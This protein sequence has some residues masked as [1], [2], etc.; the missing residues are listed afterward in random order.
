MEKK[1]NQW[2]RILAVLLFF[3]ALGFNSHHN[4]LAAN[5]SWTGG[6]WTVTG[7]TS[8]ATT[9]LATG[10]TAGPGD[11]F[12]IGDAIT[13]AAWVGADASAGSI[14]VTT[15]LIVVVG[16]ITS[17]STLGLPAS[18]YDVTLA[19]VTSVGGATL[20][21]PPSGSLTVSANATQLPTTITVNGTLALTLATA[22]GSSFTVNG[23]M[24]APALD[25]VGEMTV[26]DGGSLTSVLTQIAR[27]FRVQS[28]AVSCATGSL[29]SVGSITMGAA[30]RTITLG[31]AT[32]G[33][34]TITD[35][36]VVATGLPTLASLAITRPGV[37]NG[38]DAGTMVT[39]SISLLND[40]VWG[41]N[42]IGQDDTVDNETDFLAFT[43]IDKVT[44]IDSVLIATT[45][46]GTCYWLNVALGAT[47]DFVTTPA[48]Y[49]IMGTVTGYGTYL[50]SAP[51]SGGMSWKVG[52]GTPNLQWYDGASP[53]GLPFGESGLTADSNYIFLSAENPNFSAGSNSN[54]NFLPNLVFTASLTASTPS[55]IATIGNIIAPAG[56]NTYNLVVGRNQVCT[57]GVIRAYAGTL[58]LAHAIGTTEGSSFFV[59]AGSPSAIVSGNGTRVNIYSPFTMQDSVLVQNTG[60][61]H[62]QFD[63]PTY[64][65]RFMGDVTV[66]TSGTLEIFGAGYSSLDGLAAPNILFDSTVFVGDT[67][68]A[69]LGNINGRLTINNT[70]VRFGM[71]TLA[72]TTVPLTSTEGGSTFDFTAATVTYS[73][74][75]GAANGAFFARDLTV[76][77]DNNTSF[78]FR[79]LQTSFPIPQAGERNLYNLEFD[80]TMTDTVA[81]SGTILNIWGNYILSDATSM[82][83][84]DR[85]TVSVYGTFDAASSWT[86]NEFPLGT[87]LTL[88]GPIASIGSATAIL[89]ELALTITGAGRIDTGSTYSYTMPEAIETLFSFTMS[90]AGSTLVLQSPLAISGGNFNLDNGILVLAD[91]NDALVVDPGE[92]T[93]GGGGILNMVGGGDVTVTFANTLRNDGDILLRE[94]YSVNTGTTS[95]LTIAATYAG[96]GNIYTDSSS[97][98]QYGQTGTMNSATQTFELPASVKEV[99]TLLFNINAGSMLN[100]NGDL[101]VITSLDNTA[102][103]GPLNVGTNKLTLLAPPVAVIGTGAGSIDISNS[104][105]LEMTGDAAWADSVLITSSSSNVIIKGGAWTPANGQI[106]ALNNLIVG[107]EAAAG[108]YLIP[109]GQASFEIMGNL[110]I[111]ADANIATFTAT[112]INNFIVNGDVILSGNAFR[113]E[114]NITAANVTLNGMLS[115]NDSVTITKT[116]TTQLTIGGTAKRFQLHP[117]LDTLG[118]LTLNR[119]AGLRLNADSVSNLLDT[120]KVFVFGAPTPLGPGLAL[121]IQ[122][123]QFDLNGCNITFAAPED[124]LSETS[125][126]VVINTGTS[127]L[128]DTLTETRGCI[129]SAGASSQ[130]QLESIGF[131]GGCVTELNALTGSARR[132]PKT[133]NVPEVG[134]ATARYYFLVAA[135]EPAAGITDLRLAYDETELISPAPALKIYVDATSGGNATDA[136]SNAE[137][138]KG[139]IQSIPSATPPYVR[140]NQIEGGESYGS[141]GPGLA[142]ALAGPWLFALASPPGDFGVIKRFVNTNNNNLWFDANNWDPIGVPTILDQVQIYAIPGVCQVRITGD[143]TIAEAG[144]LVL[145]GACITLLPAS[146]SQGQTSNLMVKGNIRVEGEAAIQGIDGRN[147][148]NLMIGDGETSNGQA[149]SSR[150]SGTQYTSGTDLTSG[151][152][153]NDLIINTASFTPNDGMRV[154]G[155]VR[156]VNNGVL[157]QQAGEFIFWGGITPYIDQRLEVPASA[158]AIFSNILVANGARVNTEANLTLLGAFI[159]DGSSSWDANGG[160]V[161]ATQTIGQQVW[162]VTAP[163]QLNLF[164]LEVGASE[165]DH[166]PQGIVTIKANFNKVGRS[167]LYADVVRFNSTSQTQLNK[168]GGNLIFNRLQ[169]Y[170]RTSCNT[171]ASFNIFRELNVGDYATLYCQSGTIT[172]GGIVPPVTNG[173]VKTY[174]CQATTGDPILM[175]N[176]SATTLRHF[177]VEVLHPTVTPSNWQLEGDL[178]VGDRA[179]TYT[180]AS[181]TQTNGTTTTSNQQRRRIINYGANPD[182]ITFNKLFVP[183]GANLTTGPE[184][185]ADMI[186]TWVSFVIKNYGANAS[187]EVPSGI[188]IGS[189]GRFQQH[190]FGVVYFATDGNVPTT[191]PAKTIINPGRS[192]NLQFGNI[193]IRTGAN[194]A[195]TTTSEFEIIGDSASFPTTLGGPAKPTAEFLLAGAG[196]SFTA[197]SGTVHFTNPYSGSTVR[198]S[199]LA[200]ATA[201]FAHFR[202]ANELTLKLKAGDEI[203]ISGDVIA[204]GLSV[205]DA[206]G[207]NAK[208]Q[209]NGLTAPQYFR[210]TSTNADPFNFAYLQ[211][212]KGKTALY[213]NDPYSDSTGLVFLQRKVSIRGGA[214]TD[215]STLILASGVLKLGTDTLIV[216][217]QYITRQRGSIAGDNGTYIIEEGH[218]TPKL[219]DAFFTIEGKPTL[220]NMQVNTTHVLTNDLTVNNNLFL[221]NG[222]FTLATS[223]L[224]GIVEPKKL[225]IYGNLSRNLGTLTPGSTS[226]PGVGLDNTMSRL[227]LI[228]NGS[229]IGGLSDNFFTASPTPGFRDVFSITVGR[230]ETLGGSLTMFNSN[231]TIATGVNTLDLNGQRLTLSDGT[232]AANPQGITIMS[233]NISANDNSI[234][235]FKGIPVIPANTFAR[236]ECGTLITSADPLD[237]YCSLTINRALYT[238][239]V[240]SAMAPASNAILRTGDNV[241][242]FG[243]NM[244]TNPQAPF[245]ARKYV[246]G[247]L[248]KTV[249]YINRET[250][251]V[252]YEPY[253][254]GYTPLIMRFASNLSS[255]QIMVSSRNV[256]P[257]AGRGGNPENAL[258]ISWDITPVGTPLSDNLLL[259]F[260]WT[261][262]TEGLSSVVAAST[263]HAGKV[264]AAKWDNGRWVDYR[265]SI[266]VYAAGIN[267]AQTTLAGAANTNPVPSATALTGTWGVFFANANSNESKD[268]AISTSKNKLVITSI[269]P[270]PETQVKAG[271][272]FQITFALQ[273]EY[274][275]PVVAPE[276]LPIEI[277]WGNGGLMFSGSGS[278]AASAIPAGQ[279]EFT[280]YLSVDDQATPNYSPTAQLRAKITGTYAD[281]FLPA[282]SEAFAVLTTDAGLQAS[283]IFFR[284]IT[285]TSAT[286]QWTQPTNSAGDYDKVLIMAKEGSYF[287]ADEFP[288]NGQY[289]VPN[290]VF[291]AGSSIGNAVV[292]FNG[293]GTT[294]NLID[295]SGLLPNRRYFVYAFVYSGDRGYENYKTDPSTGNPNILDMPKES[296]DDVG[297]G[298]NNTYESSVTVGTNAPIIGMLNP[299]GDVDNFN[300]MVTDA[301]KNVRVLLTDLPGD[302]TL[303]LYDFTGRRIRRS[304]LLGLSE[305]ALVVNDL[306][307]G[308]YVVRVFEVEGSETRPGAT[309]RLL[310][311]TYKNE[312]FSVT[313]KP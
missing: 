232:G 40:A 141:G 92:S 195:V 15:A 77:T 228:G 281:D 47:V 101:T 56:A 206:T 116:N 160:R 168:Q 231:L 102:S 196:S 225:T 179:G 78:Y 94:V 39:G 121:D 117:Q 13:A 154:S 256:D 31:P 277:V 233:G 11:N 27:G 123:G 263:P 159:V 238:G 155:S 237:F 151:I 241:L 310:I 142:L 276:E 54:L 103:D 60:V 274:G 114:I 271:T 191:A 107:S 14:V 275:Q 81:T 2:G 190:I 172:Y 257:T 112:G 254:D 287:T 296:D 111:I 90:K 247:N 85:A 9:I 212:D 209:L 139:N 235:D 1:K 303:E 44:V 161:L 162:N 304:N 57:L 61:L 163:G 12:T 43:S 26:G 129:Y 87:S 202:T 175:I 201:Q 269:D 217:A 244:I 208:V 313:P 110:N 157:Q 297:L 25:S 106:P 63:E 197:T 198:V 143:N 213:P 38:S 312:I 262:T 22:L 8:G 97:V 19:T 65:F 18:G 205:I 285:N 127:F 45:T 194:N 4:L 180:Q 289:Y 251:P 187:A 200:P 125:G 308:T 249:G 186:I 138:I 145:D 167:T 165:G 284:R 135:T 152:W 24:N 178:T 164:N 248:V 86:A 72:I 148:L 51:V 261:S 93:I 220:W 272:S 30:G 268:D 28:G 306:P 302:Y 37:Y 309:Y 66:T 267:P 189:T 265:N 288:A 144:S 166:E 35:G 95:I 203:F 76:I 253:P 258:N 176:T 280:L 199:S 98:L 184:D 182:A 89:D 32:V 170:P 59:R 21:I 174:S 295:V 185:E 270:A 6:E 10:V 64:T 307:A 234:V 140:V 119:P 105:T 132:Y 46:A 69:P 300:F 243:P 91:E 299:S 282:I 62:V 58:T 20:V 82:P 245:G 273:N 146:T 173:G 80:S 292:L 29:A 17:V 68:T 224:G 192:S 226:T 158:A 33:A 41:T 286:I 169:I 50:G 239:G 278:T 204:D 67:N 183:D 193:V 49:R 108:S 223:I 120:V 227:V 266:N 301:A 181:F 124:F 113:A 294:R 218:Q 133:V 70:Q 222:E 137:L 104:G 188:E 16:E 136:F 290:T 216:A 291:G 99:G 219:E 259:E 149:V 73:G 236:S 36:F 88:Y 122:N 230:A 118:R 221:N 214:T 79:T 207:I 52:G 130:N 126:N 147:R 71:D 298:T 153:V 134:A 177:N 109:T 3:I 305:E 75:V 255:Q 156:L 42:L 293:V 246:V 96:S 74:N 171:N 128:H 115:A 34:V 23:T 53:R 131:L 48:Q 242:T 84:H 283:D 55:N 7:G 311:N 83:V 240:A 264:F 211:I 215:P 279:T 150:I 100:L 252:G 210:G 250:F 229:V 5:F 260:N